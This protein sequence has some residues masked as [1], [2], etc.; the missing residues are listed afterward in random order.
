MIDTTLSS[1]ERDVIEASMEVP[2]LVD[3]WAPWCGPCKALGPLLEKLE[4]EYAGRFKLV[5]VNSDTNPELVSSF[6]LKSIP[7]VVAFVD[8]NAVA[9]FMGAQPEAYIRAFLDRLIPNPGEIEHRS[10]REALA[11]G[12]FGVAENYLKNA[13]ALDPSNDGARLD[14]IGLLLDRNDVGAA[15]V[16]WELLSPKSQNQSTHAAVS[17]RYEAAQKVQELPP[18][19]LLAR[20]IEIDGDDLAARLDLAE[21]HIARKEFAAALDQLLEIVRRDRA[22]RDDVGRIKMLEVFDMAAAQPELVD[23]YRGKLSVTLF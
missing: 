12:Q 15:S 1:F 4:R 10:A 19:D 9:Q 22:F 13:L 16:H 23:E 2:V 14:M 5:N 18:P 21:L 3:F 11:K 20:R 8:G 7:Y 6:A 17:A